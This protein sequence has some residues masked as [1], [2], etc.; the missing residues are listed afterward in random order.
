M[1]KIAILGAGRVA[2]AIAKRL[3]KSGK[4]FTVG[5]RDIGKAASNWQGPSGS[6]VAS[7]EAVSDNDVIFNATP[8]ETSVAYLK[9]FSDHLAGKVVVDVSNALLRDGNGNPR[10]LLYPGSSVGEKLQEAVP[11]A[12]IVKTLNTMLFSVIADPDILSV[13]PMAFLSGNS[14]DAKHLVRALLLEFGWTDGLIEDLGGI[15]SARGPEGFMNFVPPI[16]ANHGLAPF[17]LTIA[18]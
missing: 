17:A 1:K 7:E 4:Q 8:G 5:V 10:G 12:L 2:T 14:I 9:P 3:E 11:D 18:R 6:F 16:I 15:I 13:K